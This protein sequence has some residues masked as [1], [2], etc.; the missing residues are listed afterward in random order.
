MSAAGESGQWAVEGE[1]PVIVKVFGCRPITGIAT[2]TEG[3]RPKT[4]KG[5]NRVRWGWA[6]PRARLWGFEVCGC[7][8]AEVRK[9]RPTLLG[10]IAGY[11]RAAWQAIEAIKQ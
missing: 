8:I 7:Q 3:R 1:M 2:R 6:A 11:D 5:R 9:G 10:C 4:S